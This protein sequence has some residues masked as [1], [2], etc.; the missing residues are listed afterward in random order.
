MPLPTSGYQSR[1]SRAIKP[2]SPNRSQPSALSA[3]VQASAATPLAQN[4]ALGPGLARK[5]CRR[6]SRLPSS[7]TTAPVNAGCLAISWLKLSRRSRR[8][9]VPSVVSLTSST[10][11]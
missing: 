4:S 3:R 6:F 11:R 10:S 9:L 8:E 5:A 2:T 7:S 1:S